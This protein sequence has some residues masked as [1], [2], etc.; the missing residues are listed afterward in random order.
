MEGIDS[1]N[2]GKYVQ[3]KLG[4]INRSQGWLNKHASIATGSV[5]RWRHLG[6]MPRIDI[7]LRVCSVIA[8]AEKRTLKEVVLEA[9]EL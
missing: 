8:R 9:M 6:Q 5:N 1:I 2:F 7:F 4:D 3:Q